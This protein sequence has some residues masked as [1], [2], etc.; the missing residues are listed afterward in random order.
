VSVSPRDE[1]PEHASNRIAR[2]LG[3]S[4][5]YL[6]RAIP[7]LSEALK[8]I[9]FRAPMASQGDVAQELADLRADRDRLRKQVAELHA[10]LARNAADGVDPLVVEVPPKGHAQTRVGADPLEV[11]RELGVLLQILAE[12]RPSD[13]CLVGW[14]PNDYI[15][16]ELER[17]LGKQRPVQAHGL[18]GKISI[19]RR[20]F[21]EAGIN[22]ELIMTR[23]GHRRFALRRITP[24]AGA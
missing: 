20:L 2:R 14:K 5:E 23:N 19:L 10:I 6:M 9:E 12:E 3:T 16:S 13:D 7:P 18:E 21:R 8:L 11:P 4:Y 24:A 17:R 1:H 22:P 15:R